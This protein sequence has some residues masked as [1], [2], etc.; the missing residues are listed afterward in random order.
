MEWVP[1]KE[2]AIE[3]EV[4]HKTLL[5]TLKKYNALNWIKIYNW[6]VTDYGDWTRQC[7]KCKTKILIGNCICKECKECKQQKNLM[8]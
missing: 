2:I 8:I 6:V 1:A 3:L 4:D 7:I 5:A